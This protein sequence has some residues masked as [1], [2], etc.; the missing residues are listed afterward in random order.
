MASPYIAGGAT[1][2]TVYQRIRNEL[3]KIRDAVDSLEDLRNLIDAG[4]RD[5]AGT[6]AAHYAAYATESGITAGGYADAN[7]A[8]KASYDEVASLA[9]K[10]T[11]NASV[12]DVFAA[13]NQACAKHGV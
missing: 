13:L 2:G 4:L 8:A 1:T 7:T 10:L 9:G 3:R 11:T 6:T 12:T 5:P